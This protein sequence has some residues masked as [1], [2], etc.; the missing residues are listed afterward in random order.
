MNAELK[1][2]NL[3]KQ[4]LLIGQDIYLLSKLLLSQQC[5]TL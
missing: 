3:D 5:E 1:A 4:L 2:Q